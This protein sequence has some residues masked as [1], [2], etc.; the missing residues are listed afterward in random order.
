MSNDNL[1]D[2][3][4]IAF[5]RRSFLRTGLGGLV[6][7]SGASHLPTFVSDSA[8]AIAATMNRMGVSSIPGVPDERILVV[9]QLGGG[10]D[11]LNTVVPFGFG[12]YYKRRSNIA[13]A[14]K[15]VLKLSGKDGDQGVGL[16]TQMTGMKSLYDEGLLGIIQGVGYPNPNRSH[17]KSMDIWNTADTTATGNGWLGRYFDAECCGFGKGESGKAPASAE[18][19]SSPPGIAI[20]RTAPLAMDGSIIKPVAFE[21]ANLFRW[22]GHDIDGKLSEPYDQL[23][24]R[25]EQAH[26]EDTNADFLVRTAL[27]AQVSSDLIRK[28]VAKKPE[29]SFPQT[30][31][32]RQL[33]LVSSMIR[34]GLKTR[35]Y[36][37]THGSFDTHAGQGGAQ[38]RHGNL[39]SQLSNA[40]KAFY[41]DLKK[42]DNSN[43]VMTMCFSEFGRRVA[44]N[45]S[46][47][48]DHGTAAPMFL[49]GPMAR[50]GVIGEHPSLTDLDDGDLK[51]KIDFRSVYAGILKDWLKADASK[52]L[53]GDFRPLPVIAKA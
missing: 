37:V 50:R 46:G 10:N 27:D 39:L 7:A 36:Y 24:S 6:L 43:R 48:T 52:I 49:L 30:D 31:I 19:N 28:A 8:S 29:T 33:A 35:V 1:N 26:S 51:Y 4:N 44:Q 42:Q 14:E 23:N 17:F 47:G 32:G 22:T 2:L 53:E 20:G 18:S 25:K 13:I 34:A 41:D 3:A 38:G 9:V 15:D 45:Q 40:L 11:G 21:D 5:T 12:D 16:H